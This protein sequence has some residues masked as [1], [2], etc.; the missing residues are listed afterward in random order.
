MYEMERNDDDGEAE[1]KAKSVM[2]AFAAL[3][4][5]YFNLIVQNITR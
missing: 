5:K 2:P 4:W 3:T 1:R